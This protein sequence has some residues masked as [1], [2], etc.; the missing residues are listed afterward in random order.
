MK[1][2]LMIYLDESWE[3][4][5][6]AERRQ[7]YLDQVQATEALA[8][9]G[10]YVRGDPLYPPT[11]ATTVRVRDGQRLLTDGPFAETR[12]HLGGYMLIDVEDLDAAIAFAAGAPLARVG[13]IEVRP[14][15]EGPPTQ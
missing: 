1:Y 10:Q 5:P 8:A 6:L 12:E 11:A 2:L 3:K 14:V 7:I 4:R 15:R 9:T 13:A